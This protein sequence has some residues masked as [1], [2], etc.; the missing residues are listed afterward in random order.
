MTLGFILLVLVGIVGI[1]VSDILGADEVQ[2]GRVA[3]K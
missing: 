2:I 1:Y 3:D